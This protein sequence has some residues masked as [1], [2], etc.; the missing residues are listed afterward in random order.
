M[1]NRQTNKH[2][3][4]AQSNA[5][6]TFKKNKIYDENFIDNCVELQ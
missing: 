6:S 1:N 2:K 5:T 3:N 4:K